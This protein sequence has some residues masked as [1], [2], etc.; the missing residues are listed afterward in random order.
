MYKLIAIF[1]ISIFSFTGCSL[2]QNYN[3]KYALVLEED[4][5]KYRQMET[6]FFDTQKEE[7]ILVASS[8][9]L[10]DLGFI[11]LESNTSLGLLTGDKEREGDSA[12]AH[13]ASIG[14]ALLFGKSIPTMI[15]QKIFVTLIINKNTSRNGYNVRAIFTQ[16]ASYTDGTNRAKKIE[17]A[18][19]YT[20]FFNK[21]SQSLFLT[22]HNL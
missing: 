13:V 15:D 5:M 12:A 9:V 16:I 7:E 1:L 10:Q 18:E 8:Q 2:C 17:D 14:I 20:E 3:C 4:Y 22:A 11:L 21:L 6:R 19:I